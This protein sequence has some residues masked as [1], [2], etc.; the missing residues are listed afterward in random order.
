MLLKTSIHTERIGQLK[1]DLARRRGVV[2]RFRVSRAAGFPAL[3]RPMVHRAQL[4]EIRAEILQL[5]LELDELSELA[6]IP[7]ACLTEVT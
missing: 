3:D 1:E 6:L 5:Q 4:P 7:N 2:R